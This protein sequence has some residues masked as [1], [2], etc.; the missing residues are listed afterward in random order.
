MG[1]SSTNADGVLRSDL[2]VQFGSD[3]VGRAVTAIDVVFEIDSFKRIVDLKLTR[4]VT[5]TF[6]EYNW[7]NW[8]EIDKLQAY[9]YN[10]LFERT[11]GK[12]LEFSF[13]VFDYKPSGRGYRWFHL[14]P[15]MTD[16]AELERRI[17]MTVDKIHLFEI[18]GYE[19]APHPD[20]CRKCQATCS[21]R[22][23]QNG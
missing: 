10:Y 4:D 18:L 8:P 23:T 5:S 14:K 12:N 16:V 19:P 6:S 21:K 2:I 1:V 11:T 7:G 9:M 20:E 15:T 3:V 22:Y 17:E 13:L